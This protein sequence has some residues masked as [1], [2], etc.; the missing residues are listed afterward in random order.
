M[1]IF[2]IAVSLF[3]I[4]DPVGSARRL[5]EEIEHLNIPH[6]RERWIII[7]ELLIA[8]L[9]MVSFNFV[10]EFLLNLLH[11]KDATRYVAGGIIL[12]LSAIRMIFP[13]ARSTVRE[14]PTDEPFIVPIAIPLIAGPSLLATIMVYAHQEPDHMTVVGAAFMAWLAA[15]VIVLASRKLHDTIGK[16]GF[17]ACERLM[18]MMLTIISVQMVLQGCSLFIKTL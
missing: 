17:I 14:Y 4:M 16:R 3:L 18:G 15:I 13:M 5:P 1:S 10:G 7:R 8:L 11:V 12:F 6:Q 2:T 9:V